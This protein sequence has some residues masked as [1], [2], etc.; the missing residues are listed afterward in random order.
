MKKVLSFKLYFVNI[1]KETKKKYLRKDLRFE[2]SCY[3]Q[4]AQRRICIM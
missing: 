1:L 2:S 4:I 3:Y